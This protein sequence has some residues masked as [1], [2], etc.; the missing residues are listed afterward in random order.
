MAN[1]S[2]Y[3]LRLVPQNGVVKMDSHIIGNVLSDPRVQ[4]PRGFLLVKTRTILDVML[5]DRVPSRYLE[6]WLNDPL[7]LCQMAIRACM[8]EATSTLFTAFKERLDP[9]LPRGDLRTQLGTI[10]GIGVVMFLWTEM[11]GQAKR[12]CIQYQ[13]KPREGVIMA[14]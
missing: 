9:F 1:A 14:I 5:Q 6:H 8:S 10:I 4:P 12:V 13:R 7:V 3:F 2:C 11:M